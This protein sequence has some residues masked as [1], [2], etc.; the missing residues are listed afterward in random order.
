MSKYEEKLKNFLETGYISMRVS[1]ELRYPLIKE[2]QKHPPM[3][4]ARF[5]E[6]LIARGI[7][8]CRKTK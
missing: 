7:E 3:A 8:A 4:V 1:E 6:Y 5:A 2:M